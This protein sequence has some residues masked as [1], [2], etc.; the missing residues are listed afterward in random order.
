[1]V[2]PLLIWR[3]HTSL[4]YNSDGLGSTALNSLPASV[5]R[6]PLA[7]P[8]VPSLGSVERLPPVNFSRGGNRHE[9]FTQP[10]AR[11]QLIVALLGA[12]TS[13]CLSQVGGCAEP[14]R[15][16]W[17]PIAIALDVLRGD[18]GANCSP[19]CRGLIS[20]TTFVDLNLRCLHQRALRILDALQDQLVALLCEFF[21]SGFNLA[22]STGATG[23]L[24]TRCSSELYLLLVVLENLKIDQL[25]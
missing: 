9:C 17:R 15:D 4:K 22:T 23:T 19:L 2:S 10:S 13:K 6:L 8:P 7:T 20:L 11:Y 24:H 25:E 18:G 21:D 3:R 5:G 14:F 1:M 12:T 16:G